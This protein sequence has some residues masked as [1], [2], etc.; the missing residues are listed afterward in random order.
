MTEIE[1]K[2]VFGG[3]TIDLSDKWTFEA[4]AR[5]ATDDLDITSGQRLGLDSE[6]G[7]ANE[8]FPVSDS[9]S[10][11]AFTPRF[12]LNFQATD[13]LMAY[14]QI[15][16]GTK[17]GGFNVEYFRSDVPAEYTAYLVNCDPDNPGEP[18]PLPGGFEYA[19]TEEQK[20][21]LSFEEEEQW[22]YEVGIKSTWMDRR[23]TANL[24]LFYIDW[25]NQGLFTRAILPST[26]GAPLTSTVLT[27]A[28]Q[29]EIYGLELESNFAVT[30]NLLLFANYGFN[31]G[32]F[33]EGKDADLAL[34]TGGDGDLNG[35]TIPNSPQHSLIFGFDASTQVSPSLEGFMRSDFLYESKQY[36]QASNFGY[37]GERKI[38][39][40]RLG[41]RAERWTL[42]GYVRNLTDDDT[43]LSVFN[44]VNFASDPIESDGINDGEYP[45]MFALNPSAAGIS[46][47]NSS[48][49]SATEQTF[50]NPAITSR[51]HPPS[52][53]NQPVAPASV[54]CPPSG[55]PLSPAPPMYR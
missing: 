37:L 17:P 23:I 49:V 16:N 22:T 7:S 48:G 8:S 6:L 21:R 12:T 52:G 53:R 29:S 26:S 30:D 24:S 28:G 3:F 13:D 32:E 43:P 46:A 33:T 14:L 44:F 51:Q 41:L 1:N 36:A 20:S 11:S 34:L 5:Y 54:L 50:H 35:K 47:W 25:T 39:N 18:P 38:V 9:L 2:S 55:I 42:T 27:N 45:N 19:C 31:D 4:E 15:A 40:L 10:Y